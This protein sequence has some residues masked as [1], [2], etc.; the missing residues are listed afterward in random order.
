MLGYISF[1][2]HLRVDFEDA[3]CALSCLLNEPV[4]TFSVFRSFVSS[5]CEAERYFLDDVVREAGIARPRHLKCGLALLC[6]TAVPFKR[7]GTTL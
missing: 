3:G 6:Y 7:T 1:A 4:R 5:C 2:T